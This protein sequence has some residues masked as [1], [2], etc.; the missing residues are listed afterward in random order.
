MGYRTGTTHRDSGIEC[1]AEAAIVV[2]HQTHDVVQVY[3][4]RL[5]DRRFD[6]DGRVFVGNR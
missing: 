2:G 6:V 5:P 1:A 3:R 4:L